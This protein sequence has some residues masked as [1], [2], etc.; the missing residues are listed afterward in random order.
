M[1]SGIGLGPSNLVI[2]WSSEKSS[3]PVHLLK[4]MHMKLMYRISGYSSGP[5]GASQFL[6]IGSS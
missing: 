1:H 3:A 4:V 5:S 6:K 2:F